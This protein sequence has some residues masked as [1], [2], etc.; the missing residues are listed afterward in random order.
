LD[1]IVNYVIILV[2]N[3]VKILGTSLLT[4]ENIAVLQTFENYGHN[5]KICIILFEKNKYFSELIFNEL[6]SSYF[7]KDELKESVFVQCIHRNSVKLFVEKAK[8]KIRTNEN[9]C[10]RSYLMIKDMLKLDETVNKDL[11]F[12]FYMHLLTKNRILRQKLK[13]ILLLIDDPK[14]MLTK[15]DYKNIIKQIDEINIKNNFLN[16]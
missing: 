9:F 3:N 13:E 10:N 15:A 16:R 8:F 7:D 14:K 5:R 12:K 11:I 6:N 4:K 2:N 1:T